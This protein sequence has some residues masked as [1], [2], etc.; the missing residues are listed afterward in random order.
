MKA[1]INLPEGFYTVDEKPCEIF[2]VREGGG[3]VSN[4]EREIHL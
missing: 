1:G 2:L 3:T 4:S